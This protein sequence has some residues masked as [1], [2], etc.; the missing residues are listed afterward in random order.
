MDLSRF[1]NK[2]IKISATG[3]FLALTFYHEQDICRKKIWKKSKIRP[4]LERS[5]KIEISQNV[6]I[7]LEIK[8]QIKRE[9]KVQIEKGNKSPKRKWK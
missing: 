4:R 2:I 9:I 1:S 6:S 7:C 5:K 8:V 3:Q